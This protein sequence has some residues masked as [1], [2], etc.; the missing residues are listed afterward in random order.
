MHI[1]NAVHMEAKTSKKVASALS[2]LNIVLFSLIISFCL[3]L[4]YFNALLFSVSNCTQCSA[5]A[6]QS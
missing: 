4:C 3:Q 6:S 5:G 2:I 1:S